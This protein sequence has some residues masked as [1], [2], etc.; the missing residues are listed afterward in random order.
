MTT[1]NTTM[2]LCGV[3]YTAYGYRK[4]LA[5]MRAWGY[6]AIDFQELV[7]TETNELFHMSPKQ[8]A[9]RLATIRKLADDNGISVW[10]VHGPWRFPP[11]DGT[12][13]DLAERLEKMRR[14]LEATVML[15]SRNMVI[16]PIMPFGL[17]EKNSAQRRQA[18]EMNRDF[19]GKLIETAAKLDVVVSLENMPFS[20]LGLAR[21]EPML[22]FIREMDSP[23]LKF[24]LDTGHCYCLGDAPDE[25]VRLAGR[26]C[27]QT[28]HVHDNFGDLDRHLPPFFGGIDWEAFRKS[29][30]DIGFQGALSLENHP[31]VNFPPKSQTA[32]EMALVQ[33]A[34]YLAG[35]KI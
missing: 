1:K 32:A 13:A 34:A 17:M 31:F 21:P 2:R 29:L 26:E 33:A 6:D 23:W 24:C 10:Q 15:G 7:E 20:H 14:V 22:R 30:K 12:E 3:S 9:K 25:A 18:W 19:F 16:H 11:K 35:R 28:M 8:L 27:L 4:G 5:N